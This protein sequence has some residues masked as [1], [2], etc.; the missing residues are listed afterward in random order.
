M[1]VAGFDPGGRGKN[2]IALITDNEIFSATVKDA[3][4]ALQWLRRRSKEKVV[5]IGVDTFLHWEFVDDRPCDAWLRRNYPAVRNSVMHV[6]SAMGSMVVQGVI[7][8][9][10]A[11]K[12]WPEVLL[13]ETHPKVLHYAFTNRS[14]D[15]T[16]A[17]LDAFGILVEPDT[18]HAADALIA[19]EITRRAISDPQDFCDLSKKASN[20]IFPAGKANYWWPRYAVGTSTATR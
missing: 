17:C 20:P 9:I 14:I 4:A 15:Y 11:R 12:I 16:Q 6:N 7:F 2:G 8:A 13:N 1:V 10:E 18:E 3:R 5:A 19:A